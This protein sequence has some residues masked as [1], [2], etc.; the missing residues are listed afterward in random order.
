MQIKQRCKVSA[1]DW[2][3]C[4]LISTLVSFQSRD[5]VDH[6]LAKS[7]GLLNGG[8]GFFEVASFWGRFIEEVL[9]LV[10]LEP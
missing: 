3:E 5:F 4:A 7:N 9:C 10:N 2:S 1:H 8:A 6:A